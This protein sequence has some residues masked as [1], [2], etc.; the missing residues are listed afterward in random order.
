VGKGVAVSTRGDLPRSRLSQGLIPTLVFVG[1]VP[2]ILAIFHSISAK[3]TDWENH[4]TQSSH[5]S[6]LTVKTL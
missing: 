5:R 2:N 3:L 1:V 4:P 6:S